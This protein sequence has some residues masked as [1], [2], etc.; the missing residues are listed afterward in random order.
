[1]SESGFLDDIDEDEKEDDVIEVEPKE[2][3]EQPKP[4]TPESNNTL[5][6]PASD[7]DEVVGLYEQFEQI[8]TQLID[9]E[10]D[11]TKIQG[12]L[13]IEK[14]GW[15]KIATAFNLTVDI[16]QSRM[17]E[18]NGIIKAEVRARAVAPNGKTAV[19][20]AMCASNE[21]THMEKIADDGASFEDAY[22]I[23]QGHV[24]GELDEDKLVF[25]DSYWRL[26]KRPSEVNE[27][28]ILATAET[29]AKNRAISDCVGGGEVSAEE[30]TKEMALSS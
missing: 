13:Y 18:D 29:R 12:S 19:S 10:A 8:K 24:P 22:Q 4:A 5:I 11:M 7:I 15:R 14:S 27:H 9:R 23:A 26:I 20:S 21:S 28:N 30:I 6:T 3:N 1:M 16:V 2:V 17:W 25:V